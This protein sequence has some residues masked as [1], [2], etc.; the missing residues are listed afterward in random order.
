VLAAVFAFLH[1]FYFISFPKKV[2]HLKQEKQERGKVLGM[3]LLS[4]FTFCF[5]F[6]FTFTAFDES[7]TPDGVRF[8]VSGLFLFHFEK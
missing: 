6:R 3:R 2:K 4:R 5:A 7:E 8:R 1:F